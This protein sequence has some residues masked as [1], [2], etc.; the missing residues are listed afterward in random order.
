MT[1]DLLEVAANEIF[2]QTFLMT[3]LTTHP[4]LIQSHLVKMERFAFSK[5]RHFSDIKH[6]CRVLDVCFFSAG[7]LPEYFMHVFL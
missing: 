3:P 5:I 4:I 1:K 6:S 7:Y 2:V